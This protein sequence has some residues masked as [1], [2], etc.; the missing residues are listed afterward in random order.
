M[1]IPDDVIEALAYAD[2]GP[3][4]SRRTAGRL[5]LE[6][7]RLHRITEVADS[8]PLGQACTREVMAEAWGQVI[9]LLAESGARPGYRVVKNNDPWGTGGGVRVRPGGTDNPISDSRS[10]VNPEPV[11]RPPA[12]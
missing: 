10:S 7:D 8:L 4:L 12:S 3:A 1:T 9:D 11:D 5:A 2:G 6:A